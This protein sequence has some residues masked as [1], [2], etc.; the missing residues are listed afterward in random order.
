MARSFWISILNA[1]ADALT[2]PCGAA[3]IA[4][5]LLVAAPI[6]AQT[7]GAPRSRSENASSCPVP[8]AAVMR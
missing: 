2:H 3:L 4:I 8:P 1:T 7:A 6:L 5:A